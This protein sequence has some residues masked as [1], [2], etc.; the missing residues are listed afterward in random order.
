MDYEV[1]LSDLFISDLKS[2]V[3]YLGVR[4]D[5]EVAARIGNELLDR[6]Q[7]LAGPARAATPWCPKGDPVFL[8]PLL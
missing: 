5:G 4:A 8:Y 3:D 1:V 7:P 6:A 2:I